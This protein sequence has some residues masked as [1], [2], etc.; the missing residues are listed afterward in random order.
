MPRLFFVIRL[1]TRGDYRS[2]EGGVK[3]PSAWDGARGADP[4]IVVDMP[5]AEGRLSACRSC[6]CSTLILVHRQ[7]LVDQWRAQLAMFLGVDPKM[8]GQIGGGKRIAAGRSMS[9]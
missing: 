6:A 9:R 3:R 7:P 2:A 4:P 5:V 8:I 1:D